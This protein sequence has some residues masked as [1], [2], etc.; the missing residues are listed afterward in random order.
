MFT[1]TI[2]EIL[3]FEGSSVLAPSQQDTESK[4]V[5]VSIIKFILL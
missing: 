3:L 5:N 4:R 1:P 2:L